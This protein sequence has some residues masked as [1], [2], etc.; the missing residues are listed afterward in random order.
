M[1]WSC[2]GLQEFQYSCNSCTKI[3]CSEAIEQN[4]EFGKYRISDAA[5]LVALWLKC[6]LTSTMGKF[7]PRSKVKEWSPNIGRKLRYIYAVCP[8]YISYINIC[9][10]YINI[11]ILYIIYMVT[12][13]YDPPMCHLYCYLQHKMRIFSIPYIYMYMHLYTSIYLVWWFHTHFYFE[14]N[15]A[16]VPNWR[17][18]RCATR[19]SL[20]DDALAESGGG[21]R[22]GWIFG[23]D[24]FRS[25]EL[26]SQGTSTYHYQDQYK[27]EYV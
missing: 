6:L 10:T 20:L 23:C 14:P 12:P 19:Y 26:G 15:R 1:W 13:P 24:V 8:I 18:Q 21:V 27:Y 25:A 4:S 11:R 7:G 22:R 5:S 2:K 16:D 3:T 9:V 17:A